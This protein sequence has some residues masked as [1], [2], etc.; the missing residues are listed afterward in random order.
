MTMIIWL[1]LESSASAWSVK[2][3]K[4]TKTDIAIQKGAE[5]IGLPLRPSATVLEL[6]GKGNIWVLTSTEIPLGRI[7]EYTARP[8]TIGCRGSCGHNT[9][10]S[11]YLSKCQSCTDVKTRQGL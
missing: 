2:K 8:Y 6:H 11:N 9:H 5:A 3:K 7:W 1:T 10:G 4:L